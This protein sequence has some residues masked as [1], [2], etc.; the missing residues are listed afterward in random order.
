MHVVALVGA[1]A[2]A[3]SHFALYKPDGY[4]SNF[5]VNGRQKR[6]HHLL[7]A[8]GPF[9]NRTMAVGRLDL[10]SEG[11]LLLTTSGALSRHVCGARLEKEYWAQ[12]DGVVTDEAIARLADGVP[13]AGVFGA[14]GAPYRTRPCRVARIAAPPLPA[15]RKRVRDRRRLEGG[16]WL[17]VPTSWISLTLREG[18]NRQV[19]R[20]TSAVG[21]PCLRLVRARIGGLELGDMA[22]GEARPL[23]AAELREHALCPL[24]FDEADSVS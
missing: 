1:L 9:P 12:L 17:D 14:D 2:I 24:G 19:R 18:K 23:S 5:V 15:R 16:A 3:P 11:L 22:P 10:D 8:L 13:I 21:F 20:M 6:R 4:L 7:G